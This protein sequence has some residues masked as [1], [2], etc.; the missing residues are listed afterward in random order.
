MFNFCILNHIIKYSFNNVNIYI[1]LIEKVLRT[2]FSQ[3]KKK[4]KFMRKF[5][6]IF[7]FFS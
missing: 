4:K 2:L 7:F 6:I 1:I 3:L 5:Q